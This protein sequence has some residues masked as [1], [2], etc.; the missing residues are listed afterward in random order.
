MQ[1]IGQGLEP[2]LKDI[3]NLFQWDLTSHENLVTNFNFLNPTL[4]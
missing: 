4:F 3:F 2:L 1:T